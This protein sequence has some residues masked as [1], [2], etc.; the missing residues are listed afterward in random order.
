M[1]AKSANHDHMTF[2][3]ILWQGIHFELWEAHTSRKATV[4]V[5]QT[6]Y[7][8]SRKVQYSRCTGVV[9]ADV[10]RMGEWAV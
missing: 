6:R 7:T 9:S 4:S 2:L 10:V 8:K 5:V 1:S 3:G